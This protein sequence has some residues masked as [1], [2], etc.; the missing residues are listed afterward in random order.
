MAVQRDASWVKSATP[1]LISEALEAGELADY[2][3][4][5]TRDEPTEPD[6]EPVNPPG[7]LIQQRGS[8]WV[9][10]ATPQQISDAYD[11]GELAEYNGGTVN[12][13]GNPVDKHGRVAS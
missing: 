1:E 4:A 6:I 11:A 7:R 3:A 10:A 5:S 2:L 9:R 13:L 12:E 8:S